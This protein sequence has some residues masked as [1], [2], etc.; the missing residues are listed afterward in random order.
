MSSNISFETLF[1]LES[2]LMA[3]IL[4]MM[5]VEINMWERE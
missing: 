1:Y 2:M 3:F 4:Y 5:F